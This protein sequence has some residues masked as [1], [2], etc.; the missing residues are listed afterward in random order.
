MFHCWKK[1]AK[2]ENIILPSGHTA[3]PTLRRAEVQTEAIKDDDIIEEKKS[4]FISLK[5]QSGGGHNGRD[6]V[7]CTSWT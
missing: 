1:G 4:S 7:D 6:T 3:T 5:R 2:I